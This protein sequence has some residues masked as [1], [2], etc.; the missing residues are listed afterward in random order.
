MTKE[1]W[2]MTHREYMYFVFPKLKPGNEGP[3]IFIPTRETHRHAIDE[4]ISKGY[5]V[6]DNVLADYPDLRR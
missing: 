4:A 2:E 5:K 1:I 6:P 3:S